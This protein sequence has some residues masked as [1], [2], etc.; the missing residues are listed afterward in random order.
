[1]TLIINLM[2]IWA[3]C[4]SELSI[5]DFKGL[6]LFGVGGGGEFYLNI[7]RK[8][9]S[10][11]MAG[12]AV[13]RIDSAYLCLVKGEWSLQLLWWRGY[14][15]ALKILLLFK[16]WNNLLNFIYINT[17]FLRII[18]IMIIITLK[19]NWIYETL[20]R[21]GKEFSRSQTGTQHNEL[22]L[23][24]WAYE[25]VI[26]HRLTC[27]DTAVMNLPQARGKIMVK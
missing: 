6:S 8:S 18:I 27:A 19:L 13:K 16:I 22:I 15:A 2:M 23:P 7:S 24:V 14:E 10:P 1:M 5:H 20:N 3:R 4:S 26:L 11:A 25:T 9:R 17:Y 21:L 12:F